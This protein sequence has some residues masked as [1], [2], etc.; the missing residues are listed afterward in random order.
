MWFPN[1][2]LPMSP[3]LTLCF[4]VVIKNLV[5]GRHAWVIARGSLVSL[6]CCLAFPFRDFLLPFLCTLAITEGK[7]VCMSS[8]WIDRV[9]YIKI[10]L[11]M[12]WGLEDTNKGNIIT[13]FIHFICFMVSS[14]PRIR[15]KLKFNISK[16]AYSPELSS[17]EDSYKFRFVFWSPFGLCFD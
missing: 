4:K 12:H 16:V 15:I 10:Q 8:A 6:H 13:M 17:S 5:G 7:S 1:S 3:K 2:S 11:D 9:R 14:R